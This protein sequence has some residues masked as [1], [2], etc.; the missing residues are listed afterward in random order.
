MLQWLEAKCFQP[1]KLNA[2]SYLHDSCQ[3]AV[4]QS[5]E[6]VA[7]QRMRPSSEEVQRLQMTMKEIQ[8]SRIC[9]TCKKI[10]VKSSERSYSHRLWTLTSALKLFA[11]VL[12]FWMTYTKEKGREK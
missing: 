8:L 3:S 5:V 12:V 7:Q 9:R 11:F 1:L 2:A 10:R 6:Q 4:A